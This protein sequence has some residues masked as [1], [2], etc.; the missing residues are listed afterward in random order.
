MKITRTPRGRNLRSL[1]VAG[2]AIASLSLFAGC[3]A[4]A[5]GGEDGGSGEFVFAGTGGSY[6]EVQ[7][8][9]MLAPFSEESGISF[10]EDSPATWPKLTTQ[11]ESGN[12]TWDVVESLP[13][14]AIAGCGTVLEKIDYDVVDV[15]GLDPTMVSDCGVP[16][17]VTGYLLVYN[18]ETYGDNPPTSWADFYDVENFPGERGMMQTAHDAGLETALMADGATAEDLY[19]LD[20]DRAF[21]VLDTVV[22]QTT[23][24]ETGAQMQQSLENGSVDMIVAWPGRAYQAA[25]N[26]APLAAVWNQPLFYWDVFVVPAGAPNKEEA[27]EFI[28]FAV[29]PEPQAKMTEGIGYGPANKH[30]KPDV[31]DLMGQFVPS[32][33]DNGT[34][35][36]RDMKWWAENLEEAT[37]KW[38][39]WL[40]Q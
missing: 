4:T 34:G 24:F 33:Q 13:Y 16:S 19:P 14:Y 22:D 30:A 31:D 5:A 35:I 25:L 29:Q 6:Q 37:A 39:A 17:M 36:Q 10:M 18:T 40:N 26:G 15:S 7:S 23:F 20:Y 3:S 27:M 8:E 28:N 32:G 21:G 9:T 11:V 2:T 12:V 1:L 38:T